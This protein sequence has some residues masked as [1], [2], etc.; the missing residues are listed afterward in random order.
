MKHPIALIYFSFILFMKSGLCSVTSIL[1]LLQWGLSIAGYEAN[2]NV[3]HVSQTRR[4][5]CL[6][7]L[8]NAHLENISLYRMSQ[9]KRSV[10]W[11]VIVSVILSKKCMCTCVLN[12]LRDR[13][14]LLY[15]TL[16]TVQTSNTSCPYMSCKVHWSCWWNFRKCV[17]LGKLHQLRHLNNKYRY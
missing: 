17:I 14:I 8:P 6:T 13:A 10:F 2:L 15:S 9:E 1:I 7:L 5:E 16:Y 4:K 3:L 11:E 12:G